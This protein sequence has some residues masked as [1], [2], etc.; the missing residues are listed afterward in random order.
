MDEQ[1]SNIKALEKTLANAEDCRLWIGNLDPTATAV[2]LEG[3]FSGYNVE[4]ITFPPKRK[5]IR[6]RYGFVILK[7][8]DEAGRAMCELS[9]QLLLG[10]SYR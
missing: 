7:N 1:S 9:R 6:Q 10:H 4:S 3:F 5:R 2:E 8:A